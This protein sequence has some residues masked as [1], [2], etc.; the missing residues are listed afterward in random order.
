MPPQ[1]KPKKTPGYRKTHVVYSHLRAI[2][3]N[4]TAVASPVS[5][6]REAP[7]LDLGRV[8]SLFQTW[9]S[10][11][12][13]CG[14]LLSHRVLVRIKRCNAREAPEPKAAAGELGARSRPVVVH[15]G[16]MH[17]REGVSGR[18]SRRLISRDWHPLA[19][20]TLSSCIFLCCWIFTMNVY[21]F[22]KNN[23]ILYIPSWHTAYTTNTFYFNSMNAVGD[24]SN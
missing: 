14:D 9:I 17:V 12:V 18:S 16:G 21:G 15:H 8:T 10:S 1:I 7:P 3:Y 13:T 4:S 19:I 20:C 23:S 24:S 22:Y 11:C 2:T 6:F 5:R